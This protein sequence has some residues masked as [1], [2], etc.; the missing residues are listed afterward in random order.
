MMKPDRSRANKSGQIHLLTTVGPPDVHLNQGQG[1]D[2]NCANPRSICA[3]RGF[4][5]KSCF[6]VLRT[7]AA[8]RH[9]VNKAI[10]ANVAQGSGA[11][12]RRFGPGSQ[13]MVA[14]SPIVH[15]RFKCQALMAGKP[16]LP[17]SSIIIRKHATGA[18]YS[19]AR[20]TERKNDAAKI[21]EPQ[22]NHNTLKCSACVNG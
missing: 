9:R 14:K 10:T 12:R 22:Q 16:E 1:C 6:R 17:A 3:S 20:T 4:L 8:S 11:L 7:A 18:V 21:I 2:P 5:Q 13:C 19:P 15:I